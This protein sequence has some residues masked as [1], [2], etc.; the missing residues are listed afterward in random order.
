VA[1]AFDKY[2]NKLGSE[3]VSRLP[4]ST[5]A[6]FIGEQLNC[7]SAGASFLKYG[8]Q[9]IRRW[10]KHWKSKHGHQTAVFKKQLKSN[11]R[12]VRFFQR[13]RINGLQGKRSA[14]PLVRQLLFEWFISMRYAIDWEKLGQHIRSSGKVK[15]MGRFPRS[16][17]KAKVNQLLEDYCRESLIQGVALTTFKPRSDWW[18]RWEDEYGLSMRYP[19]RKFK[20]PKWVLAERLGIGWINQARIRALCEEVHGYDLEF[21]NWDQSPFHNNESG[22]QNVRTLAIAGANEVPLIEN[23][24]DVRERWTGN[25]TTFSDKERILRDGP[26]YAELMFKADGHILELRLR[27]Y[28]RSRGYGKWITIATAPKGSYREADVL[29]FLDTHLPTMSQ[30]RRWRVILGDDFG[31]HKTDNVWRLCWSR[32]YVLLVH[33]GGGTP[34]IQTPDTDLNQHVRRMYTAK[35]TE[36]LIRQMRS[37]VGVPRCKE[38]QCIDM[39]VDVLSHVDLHLK[40]ADGYKKTG[41]TVALDGSED[42]LIVREAGTFFREENMRVRINREVAQVREEVRSGRLSW[43]MADVRR[44]IAPYPAHKKVDA[45]LAKIEDHAWLEEEDTPYLDEDEEKD[46]DAGENVDMSGS[47]AEAAGEEEAAEE[48]S[49]AEAEGA[50]TRSCGDGGELAVAESEPSTVLSPFEAEQFHKSAMLIDTYNQS[51]D[52]L[53]ACG[54]VASI[55]HLENEIRKEK[56]RQRNFCTES[57]A[58][59]AALARQRD[60]QDVEILRQR[61]LA[62]ELNAKSLTAAKVQKQ[63]VEANALLNKRKAELLELENLLESK[64]AVKRFSVESLGQ[65]NAKGGG[66]AARKRRFEVLDRLA[67]VGAGLSPGQKNDWTWFKD[68]WDEKML[69]EHKENWGGT[70]AAWMQGIL[71]DCDKGVG[72]AMSVFVHNETR[73]GFDLVPALLCP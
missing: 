21:E 38:E 2:I 10:H 6:L 49:D 17:L 16:L 11:V 4:R 56:R 40:A 53:K 45:V 42:H 31:P 52:A 9:N 20:V 61:R 3:D 36:E 60:A 25:F 13:K 55:V 57:P 37:G 72:N 73:R 26:P 51:I 58:V 12:R 1:A 70:F 22:S 43:N 66:A 30:S 29:N 14:C 69:S 28:V 46:V 67:R 59:A 64:H 35:E 5:V 39:M 62:A 48:G 65:G 23:H 15:C 27:E 41:T 47:D 68:A 33:G 44:L 24:S 63:I 71:D 7:A 18:S 50:D 32:G 8:S 19:N 34:V 54:A